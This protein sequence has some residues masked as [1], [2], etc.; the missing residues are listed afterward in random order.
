[1]KEHIALLCD[2][3]KGTIVEFL[4]LPQGVALAPGDRVDGLVEAGSRSKLA[5]LLAEISRDGYAIGWELVL[6][7]DASLVPFHF[8]GAQL[9]DHLLLLAS[10]AQ[11]DLVTLV[12]ELTRLNNEQTNRLRDALKELSRRSPPT[13]ELYNEMSRLNSELATVQRELAR[14]NA[15]LEQLNREKN[16]LVGMAAHDLRNPMAAVF[17]LSQ[18]L[19]RDAERSLAPR[20]VEMLQH[21]RDTSEHMLALVEDLLSL[22]TLETGTLR[23]ALAPTDLPQLVG[24]AIRLARELAADKD[25]RIDYRRDC[26]GPLITALDPHKITQ[27]LDNLLS[28][29]V[30]FSHPGS[31]VEVRL[32]CEAGA[33]TI[34]VADRGVGIHEADLHEL[35]Q[36]FRAGRPGTKGERTTGLGLAIVQRIVRGH[37][38]EVEVESARDVGTTFTITLP[39]RALE[40]PPEAPPSEESAPSRLAVL[41]ADDDPISRLI[42]RVL[43]EECGHRVVAAESA[44][45]AIDALTAADFDLVVVDIEMPGGGGIAVS[46]ALRTP[47]GGRRLPVL[48]LTGHS[49]DKAAALARSP[50]FD[51][52]LR[53]PPKRR[54][55]EAQIRRVVR[56]RR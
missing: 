6:P 19:L 23:L 31:A 25:V 28:N 37:G 36:P 2:P 30:K 53:K 55:L 34:A 27:A 12:D 13:N 7:I 35:F 52:V 39:L 26:D 33:A 24:R 43:L 9:G 48:A 17:S 51:G 29:A 32:H 8:A 47:S 38:G 1:V 4:S 54:E 45:T 21:L 50:A 20:Q 5:A 41:I 46:E 16:E 56:T 18:H 44:S 15:R 49:G 14:R 3:A 11:N 42:L 22:T 40:G 10:L